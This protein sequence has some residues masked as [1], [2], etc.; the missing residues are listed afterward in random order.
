MTR[1]IVMDSAMKFLFR[2]AKYDI[3]FVRPVFR[4]VQEAGGINNNKWRSVGE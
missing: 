4:F 2:K 1:N 3:D